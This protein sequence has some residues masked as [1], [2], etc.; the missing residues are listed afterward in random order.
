[1][2]CLGRRAK[3]NEVSGTNPEKVR[4]HEQNSVALTAEF[5][6][7]Q[8]MLPMS[9]T[10]TGSF[11][12]AQ[13]ILLSGFFHQVIQVVVGLVVQQRQALFGFESGN[14]Q[15]VNLALL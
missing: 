15:L 5:V 13:S 12:S 9:A 2:G 4:S 1:M 14:R 6:V 7:D 11:L 10:N 8:H 3:Q